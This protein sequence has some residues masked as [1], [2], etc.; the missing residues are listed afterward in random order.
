MANHI[1]LA[2]VMNQD[3]GAQKIYVLHLKSTSMS[4]C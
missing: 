2:I 3:V 1:M 4:S